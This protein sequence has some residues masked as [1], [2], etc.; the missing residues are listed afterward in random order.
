MYFYKCCVG[1]RL[2]EELKVTEG[3]GT[4]LLMR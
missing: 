3:Q 4:K 1:E 2:P